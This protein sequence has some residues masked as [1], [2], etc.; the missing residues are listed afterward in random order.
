MLGGPV[1]RAAS[2]KESPVSAIRMLTAAFLATLPATA[3]A[4]VVGPGGGQA[5][6]PQQQQ[7]QQ[8]DQQQPQQAQQPQG[9][10]TVQGQ[11][12]GSQQGQGGQ[13]KGE[14]Q[15]GSLR[16]MGQLRGPYKGTSIIKMQD[17]ENGVTCYVYAPT[18]IP[19]RTPMRGGV[20]YG[21]NSIGS[22]SCVK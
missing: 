21:S 18:S 2:P 16:Y 1:R 20:S 8:P 10:Q 19:Y 3:L 12:Q 5:A 22:I 9:N 7:P 15:E 11:Q 6:Q 4:Q 14:K 17:S 13:E